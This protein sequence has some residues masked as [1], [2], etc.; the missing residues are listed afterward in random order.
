MEKSRRLS[1]IS[2]ELGGVYGKSLEER[3]LRV[4]PGIAK[5]AEA[6]SHQTKSLPGIEVDVVSQ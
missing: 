2:P 4:L 6:H 5:V 1:I 3:R